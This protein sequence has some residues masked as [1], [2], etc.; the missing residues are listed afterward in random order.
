M[1][2]QFP[3]LAHPVDY[4]KTAIQKLSTEYQIE[5]KWDGIRLIATK[6]D[7]GTRFLTRS[8][9]DITKKL[10]YLYQEF[11]YVPVGTM[12][13]G[14]LT[15]S[16]NGGREELGNIQKVIGS[17]PER[18]CKI[19]EEIGYPV[20]NVFDVLWYNR[21]DLQ[22]L[23]LKQRLWYLEEVYLLSEHLN[24]V[25][26]V[27]TDSIED[28][29]KKITGEGSE[30]IVVKDLTLSYDQSYWIRW[31]AVQ[32]IDLVVLG[33]NPPNGRYKDQQ[34]AGSLKGHLYDPQT[35]S[36]KR[37]ASIY[38]LSDVEREWFYRL[39]TDNPNAKVVVEAKYSHRFPSGGFR[40]C[41]F[42]RGRDDKKPEECT[43]M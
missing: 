41:S 2:L 20:Y 28:A 43:N 25:E 11:E 40:F 26:R 34:V 24:P 29:F 19:V 42:L 12:L 22:N 15:L 4:S 31:K 1:V 37:A 39:F 33:F 30:G 21:A 27:K 7:S 32:T 10:S 13:D 36:F 5:P 35:Q 18:A 6:D 9:R 3:R 38:G 8:Q 23:P 16:T 14:E 17:T